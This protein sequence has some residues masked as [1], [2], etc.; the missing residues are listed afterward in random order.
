MESLCHTLT[1]AINKIK[2]PTDRQRK[3]LEGLASIIKK[4]LEV[5]PV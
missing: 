3:A 4:I 5:K 2:V 1:Q